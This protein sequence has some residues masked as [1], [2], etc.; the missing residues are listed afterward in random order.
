MFSPELSSLELRECSTL[1][2]KTLVAPITVLRE[3]RLSVGNVGL[4][5]QVGVEDA[6]LVSSDLFNAF[7]AWSE[8]ADGDATWN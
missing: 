1:P 2:A 6:V 8:T 5:L 3:I 7:N 4:N